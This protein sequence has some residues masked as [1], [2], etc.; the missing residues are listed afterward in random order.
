MCGGEANLIPWHGG[1]LHEADRIGSEFELDRADPQGQELC[2]FSFEGAVDI[3]RYEE[4]RGSRILAL[5]Q[6]VGQAVPADIP[7]RILACAAGLA[8]LNAV[9]GDRAEGWQGLRTRRTEFE[10][11]LENIDSIEVPVAEVWRRLD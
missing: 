6:L 1:V 9:A 10:I 11:I 5:V 7:R 3:A 4:Q 8:G 2:E